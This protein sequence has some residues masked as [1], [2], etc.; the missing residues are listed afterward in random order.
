VLP[1]RHPAHVAKAAASAD[2]LSGGRVLL[3]IASGLYF[4]NDKGGFGAP[5]PDALVAQRCEELV[6]LIDSV[7]DANLPCATMTH[8]S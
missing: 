2:V 4:D 1:L 5:H 8:A 3:G 6:R 7:L